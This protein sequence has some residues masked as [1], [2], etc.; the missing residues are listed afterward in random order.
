MDRIISLLH[1]FLER[2]NLI[3][4]FLLYAANC[5]CTRLNV[6]AY[7]IISSAFVWTHT[8]EGYLFWCKVADDW[9]SVSHHE[10]IT[11]TIPQVI[12]GLKEYTNNELW[13][14]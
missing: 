6:P 8:E 12:D 2:R 7:L 10:T 5:G 3:D 4:K 11:V 14:I 13:E 9:I 1:G